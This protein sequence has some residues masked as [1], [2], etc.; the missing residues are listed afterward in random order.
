MTGFLEKM[1]DRVYS[2]KDFSINIAIFFSGIAGVTSYLILHDYVLTL[3]SFVI[4]FPVVK[5]IVGGLYQKIITRKGE[6]VAEKRLKMLYQSLTG[7]EKEVVKHFVMHGG[8]VMTWGQMNKLDNPEPGVESLVRRGLLNASVTVDGMRETF[9]LD[10]A[11]FNYV[12]KYRSH[13]EGMLTSE[14]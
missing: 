8:A 11:L 14:E 3:F 5:I 13:Q 10:L 4:T 6:A 12:Y 7:R 1:F 2:E 9:E